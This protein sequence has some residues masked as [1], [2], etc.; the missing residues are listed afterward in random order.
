MVKRWWSGGRGRGLVDAVEVL[1]GAELV[2]LMCRTASEGGSGRGH[3]G[4][5]G[6]WATRFGYPTYPV[7]RLLE[8]VLRR[9][10][11]VH[12][13]LSQSFGRRLQVGMIYM[14]W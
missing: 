9:I 6:E 5:G 12:L 3:V 13:E 1:Y 8:T 10:G 11:A 4:R 7:N 14:L 2:G